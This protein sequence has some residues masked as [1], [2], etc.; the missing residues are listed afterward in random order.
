VPIKITVKPQVD[1]RGIRSMDAE[2][3]RLARNAGSGTPLD[4]AYKQW[5]KI[6]SSYWQRRFDR[7]SK[8]GG[9][10]AALAQSTIAARRKGNKGARSRTKVKSSLV[11]G[12]RSSLMRTRSGKLTNAGGTFSIL[13][14]TNMLFKAFLVGQPGNWIKRIPG[15]IEAGVGGDNKNGKTLTIGRLAEIH[16]GGT[17]HIPARPMVVRPDAKTLRQMSN[18]AKV[19]FRRM[20]RQRFSR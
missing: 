5:G 19:A 20:I 7:Y 6:A 15:G 10:W 3:R 17:V 14:D 4:A 9:D 16:Q 13:R 12:A 2:L 1:L 8:G 18:V 11:K